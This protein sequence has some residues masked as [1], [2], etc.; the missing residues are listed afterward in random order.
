MTT[1]TIDNLPLNVE[2][3][4]AA[5]SAVL[6]GGRIIDSE[7]PRSAL[8]KALAILGY[9]DSR[10]YR[11]WVQGFHGS[12]AIERFNISNSSLESQRSALGR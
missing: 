4:K 5:M 9:P 12:N 1:L 11:V 3:D 2:L 10:R 7:D 8:G 6:G